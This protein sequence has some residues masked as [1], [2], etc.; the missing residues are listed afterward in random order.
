MAVLGGGIAVLGGYGV[1]VCAT[2]RGA[3]SAN[4]KI[5]QRMNFTLELLIFPFSPSA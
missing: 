5:P 1:V 3:N 2:A 4:G